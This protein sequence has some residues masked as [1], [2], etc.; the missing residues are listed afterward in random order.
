MSV[1]CWKNTLDQTR[2][3]IA[4]NLELFKIFFWWH[5]VALIDQYT[6]L[7]EI[8]RHQLSYTQL[9]QYTACIFFRFNVSIFLHGDMS[10]GHL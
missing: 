6:H 3:I 9:L 7:Y 5:L 10:V 2:N 8:L 1:S 4:L